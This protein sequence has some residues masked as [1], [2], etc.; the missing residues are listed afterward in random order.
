MRL[1]QSCPVLVL[2]TILCVVSVMDAGAQDLP[3]STRSSAVTRS[4]AGAMIRSAVLPGW[5]QMYNRQWFKAVLVVGIEAGLAGNAMIMNQ[6]MMDSETEDERA[7][8]EHHRGTFI[9]WFAGIYLLNILDAFV[10]AHLFE[11]DVSPELNPIG[12]ATGLSIK[13]TL[14]F[15]LKPGRKDQG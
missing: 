3:D 11:F 13:A 6:K 1:S 15:P 9:W 10:D 14:C 2:F 12:S 8:Y 5:G 4:P 7:F